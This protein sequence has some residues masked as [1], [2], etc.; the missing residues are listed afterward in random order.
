MLLFNFSKNLF[1][2]EKIFE[3][4]YDKYGFY[5]FKFVGYGNDFIEEIYLDSLLIVE[6]N[7]ENKFELY[8]IVEKNNDIVNFFFGDINFIISLDFDE[9]LLWVNCS[10][11]FGDE[12]KWFEYNVSY[13]IICDSYIVVNYMYGDFG[14]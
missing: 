6:F 7:F 10:F 9:I 3:L 4:K 12:V 5:M 2:K 11:I 1:F 8:I 14:N 13:N